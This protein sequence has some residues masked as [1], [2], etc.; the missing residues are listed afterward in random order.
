MAIFVP[1]NLPHPAL[2]AAFTGHRTY[3]READAA[4]CRSIAELHAAG[5]RTFM[6]GMAVGFD[7]AAAE[8]VLDCR[9][10]LP[11]LR[12]AAV[13][14]FRGQQERFSDGDRERFARIWAAADERIMLAERYYPACYLRRDDWLV[15]HAGTLISWYDGSPGGT[16]YTLERALNSG[17]RLLHL[18]PN[19]PPE[20][21]MQP[22]LFQ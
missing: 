16:R 11:G 5:V 21:M 19:T 22:A 14:P 20:V 17:R 7:L 3:R 12:L 6:S 13:V 4:I 2:C 9:Q 10:Q 8:A 18:H 15:A 1:M